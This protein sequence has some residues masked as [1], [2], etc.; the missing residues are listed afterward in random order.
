VDGARILVSNK[1]IPVCTTGTTAG[2]A[3]AK[4]K[5]VLNKEDG[6]PQAHICVV[7]DRK[8]GR[9]VHVHEFFGRCF[10][11]TEFAR[12]ALDTVE[13]LGRVKTA[14]LKVLHAPTLR[15]KP[16]TVLRV[17]LA[18]L[19]IIAKKRPDRRRDRKA[20]AAQTD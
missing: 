6:A 20:L 18:S 15:I 19:K 17:D 13:S 9:V 5:K 14:G 16:E 4:G 8:D 11:P 2:G 3:M 1:M 7:Y 10:E 12:M